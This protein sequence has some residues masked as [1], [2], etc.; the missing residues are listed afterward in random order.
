MENKTFE[1]L[2][3][4]FMPI[5]KLGKNMDFMTISRFLKS[6]FDLG[7][8][9]YDW[10]KNKKDYNYNDFYKASG[11]SECDIFKCIE[12]GKNYIPCGNELFQY[13]SK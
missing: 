10:W 8:S 7:M 9:T 4:Q 11:D 12:N 3:L 1:Y 2:G 13:T 6:D 5:K